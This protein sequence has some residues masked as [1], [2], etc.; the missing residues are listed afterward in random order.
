MAHS[1]ISGSA[2]S[3]R[4]KTTPAPRPGVLVVDDEPLVRRFIQLVAEQQGFAAWPAANGYEGVQLFR[5]HHQ[6]I[7]LVLLDVRMPGL[8]GPQTLA[9]LQNIKPAVECCFMTGQAGEYT[10]AKVLARGASRV[11]L[12]PFDLTE[13]RLFLRELASHGPSRGARA[14]A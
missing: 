1:A 13:I 4:A 10:L 7:A 3:L 12:K 9:A 14:P 5:R 6:E 2:R 11:F 8:D